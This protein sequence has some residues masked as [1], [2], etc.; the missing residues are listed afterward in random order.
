MIVVEAHVHKSHIIIPFDRNQDFVGREDILDNIV[1]NLAPKTNSSACQMIALEGLGGIGKTQIALE[2]AYRV[3]DAY[4]ECNIFWIPAVDATTFENAYRQIGQELQVPGMD[5]DKA[6]VKALI[7]AALSRSGDDWLL[8][9]DNA[10][11]VELLFGDASLYDHLP[12][13]HK[14]SILFTTRT[15]EVVGKLD[16]P[17]ANVVHVSEMSR[18]EAIELMQRYLGPRQMS[19]SKSATELLD[20]LAD[21]PLAIKQASAYIDKTGITITRYLEHC[22]SSNIKFTELLSKDFEDRGRYKS[23]QNPITTTWLISFRHISRD[24]PLAAR[25]LKYM[26]FLSEKDIPRSLISGDDELEM[27]EAIGAL[28]AYAFITQRADQESYDVHR[29]VQLAMRNW[30]S[31]EGELKKSVTAAI[32]QL[33]EKFPFPKH[34][35]RETWIR[36]LPHA[37]IALEF[38]NSSTDE[39]VKSKS[40]LLYN[41]AESNYILGKY[42]NAEGLYQDTLALGRQVLGDKHPRTL[43]SM[44]NLAVV[45]QSQGKYE[46]AEAMHRKTLAL[47]RQVLGDEHLY[48]LTSISNLAGVLQSQGKYEEAEAMHRKTLAL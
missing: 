31:Q 36:Y 3:R 18:P 19:D 45:L 20:F 22:R 21:L 24:N 40:D 44:N 5:D 14:G 16:I 10:D 47:T 15:H 2:A 30:L 42:Q 37:M 43:T 33:D 9:V 27:D 32:Q 25:Y 1:Q 28:R 46:E 29:L 26:S 4:P 41:T 12:S 38:C 34:E 11:D 7:K 23:A 8:I 6:D 17:R 39:V 13:S 48:T 35:N